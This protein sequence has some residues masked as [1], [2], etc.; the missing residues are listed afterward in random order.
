MSIYLFNEH[1]G[2]TELQALLI[3]LTESR[4][5]A[6]VR[7]LLRLPDPLM[8]RELRAMFRVVERDEPSH[9]EPYAACSRRARPTSKALEVV[10]DMLT[11]AAIVSLKLPLLMLH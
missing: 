9:F 6:Q 11:H 3:I 7:S 8:D 2:Y 1:R 5:L 4:G 10:A